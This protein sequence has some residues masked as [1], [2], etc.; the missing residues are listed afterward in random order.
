MKNFRKVK[1]QIIKLLGDAA[2]GRWQVIGYQ[3]QTKATGQ[4]QNN[5]RMIQVFFTDGN[6]PKNSGRMRGPKTHD[7]TI[8]IDLSA[9][10]AA[11]GDITVLNNS[12]ATAEQKAIALAGIKDAAEVADESIDDLIEY[13][14]DLIMDARNEDLGLDIGVITNRWVDSI[15]KD[16]ILERG[17]L[18]IRTAMIKYSC[19]V[20]ETVPGDKGYE[21]DEV[22]FDSEIPAGD[23]E[24]A[25]I[26]VTNDNT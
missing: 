17:D 6:F 25:G 18:I 7:I 26:E 5:D 9:S 8:E 12:N 1:R 19:R 24:G 15:K 3:N 20:V 14:F 4:V 16:T 13:I 10:A 23:T 2:D 22:V 11:K 21:P